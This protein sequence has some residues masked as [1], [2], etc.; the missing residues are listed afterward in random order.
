MGE[1]GGAASFRALYEELMDRSG[2]PQDE[3]V[4][5]A[6][7]PKAR[8]V[9]SSLGR[10]GRLNTPPDDYAVEREDLHQ[11]YALCRYR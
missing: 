9:L 6:W 3:D 11:W 7:P 4:L 1:N 5:V 10:Y 2:H 8:Q